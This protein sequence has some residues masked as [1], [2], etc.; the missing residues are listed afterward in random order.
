MAM[1]I[2]VD[3]HGNEYTV[4]GVGLQPDNIT[5]G[6]LHNKLAVL[7]GG[8]TT[9]KIADDNVT[10]AK[11]ADGAVTAAKLAYTLDLSST[12]YT[13]KFKTPSYPTS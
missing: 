6:V 5:L 1:M 13:V 10:T 12:S 2:Y 4:S 11:I 7:D 8:V 9:E 3:E